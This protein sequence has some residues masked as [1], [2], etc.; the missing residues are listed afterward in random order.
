MQWQP[1]LFNPMLI[2]DVRKKG[3][4]GPSPLRMHQQHWRMHPCRHA[5]SCRRRPQRPRRRRS[6]SSSSSTAR[7]ETGIFIDYLFL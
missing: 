3:R 6:G 7:C 5:M 4:E 1:E 2:L